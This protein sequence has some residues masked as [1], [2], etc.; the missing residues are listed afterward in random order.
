MVIC[1]KVNRIYKC[2]RNDTKCKSITIMIVIH[3]GDKIMMTL[4]RYVIFIKKM[5][6]VWRSRE[7]KGGNHDRDRVKYQIKN[8]RFQ[9]DYCLVTMLLNERLV[10]KLLFS[11]QSTYNSVYIHSIKFKT[12]QTSGINVKYLFG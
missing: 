12:N 8:I 6:F 1:L 9:T 4:F 7:T 2:H 11:G 10:R 3:T 5:N